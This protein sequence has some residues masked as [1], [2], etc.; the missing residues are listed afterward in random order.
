VCAALAAAA[1]HRAFVAP[2][3]GETFEFA[4]GALKKTRKHLPFLRAEKPRERARSKPVE[5]I[6]DYAPACGRV[7]LDD[8]AALPLDELAAFI[9]G[10]AL[11]RTLH[12][13]DGVDLSGRKP[14]FALVLRV[15][16][17]DSAHVFELQTNASRFEPV[18]CANPIAT[19]AL[20]F[21][22]WATDL[23]DVLRGAMLP[24][25]LLGHLRAWNLSP[26]PLSV[27]YA[28]WRFFDFLHRYDAGVAFYDQRLH[29]TRHLKPIVRAG[30]AALSRCKPGSA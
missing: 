21:E 12:A 1:P 23:A 3:P 14:A 10:R 20:G 18:D 25:R 24:Q 4:R 13:L 6:V 8:D 9:Y 29:E 30:S 17:G 27:L 7:A 19:Y 5:L 16:D 11:F 22:C 2:R 26:A 15:D 28:V